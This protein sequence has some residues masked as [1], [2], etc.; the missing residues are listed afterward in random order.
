LVARPQL[1]HPA[2]LAVQVIEWPLVAQIRPLIQQGHGVVVKGQCG[3][4]QAP[5]SPIANGTLVN[6]VLT[7]VPVQGGVG[8]DTLQFSSFGM[9][10][11]DFSHTQG[12]H[13]DLH[14]LTIR[15]T[16]RSPFDGCATFAPLP[17]NPGWA[18]LR[19]ATCSWLKSLLMAMAADLS[20]LVNGPPQTGLTFISNAVRLAT[21]QNPITIG[22][23]FQSIVMTVPYFLGV[24]SI[25][26]NTRLI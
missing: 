6:E 26:E 12:D 18:W 2:D 22:T 1:Q 9:V 19:G 24:G 15:P 10:A 20:T 23:V 8:A 14:S 17:Q 7:I 11:V 5:V 16:N 3:G 25:K 13:A 4:V 21:C